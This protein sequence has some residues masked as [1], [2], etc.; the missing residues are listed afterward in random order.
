MISLKHLF[1]FLTGLFLV[2]VANAQDCPQF[3]RMVQDSR[4]LLSNEKYIEAINKLSAAREY[5]PQNSKKIDEE[6][7]SVVKAIETKKKQADTERAKAETA[8]RQAEKSKAQAE[9]A[10]VEQTRLYE[11]AKTQGQRARLEKSKADSLVI[12]GEDL[13]NTLSSD[14]SG[15][16]FDYLYQQGNLF[17]AYDSAT[18]RR[19]YRQAHVYYALA[20]FMQ[21]H[22]D[23]LLNVLINCAN[24][25]KDAEQY[26]AQGVLDSAEARYRIVQNQLVGIKANAFYE[27]RQLVRI[28]EVRQK[29][30]QL[31]QTFSPTKMHTLVLSG[32]WWTIPAEARQ[33]TEIRTVIIKQNPILSDGLS[34]FLAGLPALTELHVDS[35]AQL[36]NLTIGGNLKSLERLQV[37]GND[38]LYIINCADMPR[39]QH[40][41]ISGNK[42]LDALAGAVTYPKLQTFSLINNANLDTISGFGQLPALAQLTVSGNDNLGTLINFNNLPTL[43]QLDVRQNASLKQLPEWKNTPSL[44]RVEIG[45]NR[46]LRTLGEAK[47]LRRMDHV[48]VYRNHLRQFNIGIQ[49]GIMPG[50]DYTIA[51]FPFGYSGNLLF[52]TNFEDSP[53]DVRLAVGYIRFKN[54]SEVASWIGQRYF[55]TN[56]QPIYFDDYEYWDGNEKADNQ[57]LKLSLCSRFKWQTKNME[58]Y[59]GLGP[60]LLRL[61]NGK[62]EAN[63]DVKNF[64]YEANVPKSLSAFYLESYGGISWRFR[65]FKVMA[66]IG[67]QW[68]VSDANFI[69]DQFYYNKTEDQISTDLIP[70][71]YYIEYSR[72]VFESLMQFSLGVSVPLKQY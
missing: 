70:N 62:M 19:E 59:F 31:K 40:L 67:Y 22:S 57:Y 38:K 52:E 10:R 69:D 37:S 72:P 63:I 13:A 66:E 39:L 20:R 71:G 61:L 12:K 54:I 64:H 24:L 42:V 43:T 33:M 45:N 50:S 35:C 5:C 16:I 55:I 9:A 25:G 1:A 4:K 53:T 27:S 29:W 34:A 58:F 60:M 7:Q 48:K 17:F 51:N 23:P 18:Q 56:N 65:R 14:A 2:T 6:I 3:E 47:Y 8:Q 26:Y 21:S 30:A 46:Q 15:N 36:S 32:A 49:G 28:Q 68:A 11:E 44:E 41:L